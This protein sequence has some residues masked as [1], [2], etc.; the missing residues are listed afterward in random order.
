M[1]ADR[2]ISLLMLL[3]ARG[4]MTAQE[5]AEQLEVSER[6]IYRDLDALSIAGIPIYGERGP[7]GGISLLDGYQTR[8]TGL[9]GPEAQALFLFSM[10]G[11]LSDLGLG[12]ALDDAL[13]KLSA[14]LPAAYRDD[15]EQMRQ[16]IHLDATWWYYTREAVPH[17]P[18]LQEAVCQEHTL[19]LCYRNE[20]GIPGQQL[21]QPYGLVSKASIWFL[22]G[23]NGTSSA[24]QVFRVSRIQSVE[25]TE[26]LFVR[27]P[28]FDLATY[29]HDYCLEV[30][31][32][33]PYLAQAFRATPDELP[34]AL[35]TQPAQAAHPAPVSR[36][37]RTRGRQQKKPVTN[38]SPIIHLH[39]RQNR[40]TQQKKRPSP[41]YRGQPRQSQQKKEII[42]AT[43]QLTRY[44][45][46]KAKMSLS[47][48]KSG[49]VP[50][51]IKK[52]HIKKKNC[53]DCS[54]R[55]TQAVTQLL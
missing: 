42:L 34:A 14:S 20:S 25:I 29:W 6:T 23:A 30:E 26:Q 54:Q 19:L 22:V 15:A 53:V 37:T 31:A 3:Q 38:G 47:K 44:Q 13:L 1:R 28:D 36:R 52:T 49:N 8:L 12:K 50:L 2:L 32:S 4:R 21:V 55:G 10:A 9:T 17:L 48:E 33:H 35:A 27:P 41:L 39:P 11:P 45:Q 7:G 24:K 51:A 5:L 46:K 40:R 18:L 43:Q 16:R